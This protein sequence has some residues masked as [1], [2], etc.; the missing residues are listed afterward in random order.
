MKLAK[1]L[2]LVGIVAC[3][4]LLVFVAAGIITWRLF[5][6]LIIV[7]AIFAYFIIPNMSSKLD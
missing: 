7:V 4:L 2:G 3:V 5:W 6:M 1:V